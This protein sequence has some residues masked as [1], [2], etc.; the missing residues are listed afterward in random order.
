MGCAA[1]AAVFAACGEARADFTVAENC[2]PKADIVIPAKPLDAERYA[3]DELKYHLDK[4]FGADFRIVSEDDLRGGGLP[5]RFF[6]GDTKAA[7][8]AGIPGRELKPD[9]RFL[10]RKM[11]HM[12]WGG[13]RIDLDATYPE[14][15]DVE[16]LI[17]RIEMV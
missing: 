12:I 9:E 17:K 5:Y 6:L 1:F 15:I 2:V 10:K 11:D 14:T 8:A 13:K 3:A 7:K 16:E 4:A